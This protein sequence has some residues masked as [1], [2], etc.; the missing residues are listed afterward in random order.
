MIDALLAVDD[1]Y[2]HESLF[3]WKVVLAFRS[4]FPLCIHNSAI[5][6][7]ELDDAYTNGASWEENYCCLACYRRLKQRGSASV[8]F[9]LVTNC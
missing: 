7:V 5:L 2:S 1:N 3:P 6:P 4:F 8:H 9:S